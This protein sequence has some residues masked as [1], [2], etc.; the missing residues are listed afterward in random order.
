M[1]FLPA[2]WLMDPE[3]DAALMQFQPCLAAVLAAQ[4]FIAIASACYLQ[5][6]WGWFTT[7]CV[8]CIGVM[9]VRDRMDVQ[10]LVCY[11]I[12]CTVDGMVDVL[13]LL[14]TRLVDKLI[15]NNATHKPSVLI[16]VLLLLQPISAFAGTFI[17]VLAY[18]AY[19]DVFDENDLVFPGMD[20]AYTFPEMFVDDTPSTSNRDRARRLLMSSFVPFQGRAHRIHDDKPDSSPQHL[21]KKVEKQQQKQQQPP[22]QPET[23]SNSNEQLSATDSAYDGVV[24]GSTP[25]KRNS[26]TV[27][28]VV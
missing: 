27:P 13:Q 20:D 8:I 6:L 11:G 10:S 9:T 4:F 3:A 24:T 17:S 14:D 15:A 22:L 7:L 12:L 1:V 28:E 5:D 16:A 18:K 26:E 25:S 2:A 19:N 21:S 23:E